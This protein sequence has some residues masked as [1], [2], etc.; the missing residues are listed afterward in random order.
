MKNGFDGSDKHL[1]P[2]EMPEEFI[3]SITDRYVELADRIV[4]NAK[5]INKKKQ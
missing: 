1:G 3:K 2:P 5:G 4:G